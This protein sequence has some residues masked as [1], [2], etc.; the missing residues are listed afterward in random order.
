MPKYTVTITARITKTIN[1]EANSED[2]AGKIA[3]PDL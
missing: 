1:V 3:Q 2:E